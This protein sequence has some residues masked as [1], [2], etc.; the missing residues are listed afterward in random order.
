MSAE[1]TALSFIAAVR[2]DPALRESVAAVVA[3]GRGLSAVVDVAAQS[4][5][6]LQVDD[7]RA[8]FTADWGMRR[9]LYLRD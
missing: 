4:G 1:R 8:A 9:A 7:L 6:A 2:S 5:F 3:E